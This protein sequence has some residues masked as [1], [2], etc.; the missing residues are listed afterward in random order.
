M[1]SAVVEYR[2]VYRNNPPIT[3][4]KLRTASL[5][6]CWGGRGSFSIY[7]ICIKRNKRKTTVI[8]AALIYK[9]ILRG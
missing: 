2:L 4:K 6:N 1:C 8:K 5:T 3:L 7:F 9:F